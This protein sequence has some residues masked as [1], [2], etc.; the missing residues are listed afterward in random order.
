[1]NRSEDELVLLGRAFESSL[2]GIVVG[3]SVSPRKPMIYVNTAV[4]K[5]TGFA[6]EDMIGRDFWCLFGCELDQ[7]L[8]AR[9]EKVFSEARG[10]QVELRGRRR[11]GKPIWLKLSLSP[12][13][14]QDGQETHYIAVLDDV[15]DRK[16]F[17]QKL[18]FRAA[19]DGLTGLPNQG[20]IKELLA[21][22]ISSHSR[23]KKRLC[24]AFV[25]LD[26]FKNINDALGHACGD[27][28]LKEVSTRFRRGLRASDSIAR[29]G[30]DE[31]IIIFSEIEGLAAA[32]TLAE[33][34][35]SC[36]A[37][38]FEL[39][40]HLV[41]ISA[42]I[43]LSLWPDDGLRPQEL[44]NNADTALYQA[45][46]TGRNTYRFF[47]GG[48][49]QRRAVSP[50]LARVEGGQAKDINLFLGVERWNSTR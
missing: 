27:L 35:L 13:K 33:K 3:D 5:I 22:A 38:P 28:L 46:S 26:H 50:Y 45:K 43:G 30:G 15:T 14:D 16:L 32:G 2:S 20:V 4:Q 40:G 18:S 42:S 6:A 9:I 23:W 17:E 34:V 37:A 31:F 10:G 25:D 36:F 1:M 48:V 11:D 41:S 8:R 49:R 7:R 44:L 47:S 39:G 29:L 24:V 21:Q 12:V 19:H